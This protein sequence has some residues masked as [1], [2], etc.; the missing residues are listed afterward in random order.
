MICLVHIKHQLSTPG[1]ANLAANVT[2]GADK[3][4]IASKV[5]ANDDFSIT[6]L[7]GTA[8]IDLSATIPLKIL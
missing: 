7:L 5:A 8:T 4:G 3:A 2:A 6:G 1:E